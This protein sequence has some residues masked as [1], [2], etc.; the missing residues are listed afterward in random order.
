MASPLI[1]V[2][3]SGCLVTENQ[4][5]SVVFIAKQWLFQGTFPDSKN[6]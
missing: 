4:R 3:V 2:I 6:R 1:D 5:M